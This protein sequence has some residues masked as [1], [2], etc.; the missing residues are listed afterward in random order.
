MADSRSGDR[1]EQAWDAVW[2]G[3]SPADLDP[4]LAEALQALHARDHVPPADPAFVADVRKEL[5]AAAPLPDSP[6]THDLPTPNGRSAV[7]PFSLPPR[8]H[9]DVAVRSF[10][11]RRWP[12]HLATAALILL[13]LVGS[14]FAFGPVQ[15][16]R[17]VAAPESFSTVSGLP[18]TAAVTSET[19]LD[20]TVPALPVGR[21]P[22]AVDR[23]NLLPSPSQVVLPAIEGVALMTVD[24][25]EVTVTAGGVE[26]TLQPG[27]TLDVTNQ[28]ILFRA[29][30]ADKAIAYVV[31]V[32]PELQSEAGQ[33]HMRLWKDGDPLVHAMDFVIGAG[34]EDL[35]GGPGRLVLEQLTLPP[36]T[37]CRRRP[38]RWSGPKPGRE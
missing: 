5:L 33:S 21:A 29:S 34:A 24:T 8:P 26:H 16:G 20:T 30:G 6:A 35:P 31:Y 36:G 12:T 28:E 3:E 23:W 25:G 19:L 13:T 37:A 11:V 17:Q 1:L 22:V 9:A 4:R 15:P 18:A 14:F 10:P 38:V 7:T 2:R 32:T 27:D